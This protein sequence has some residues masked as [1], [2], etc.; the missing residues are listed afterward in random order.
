VTKKQREVLEEIAQYVIPSYPIEGY[1]AMVPLEKVIY[2]RCLAREAL[3]KADR[4]NPYELRAK[5]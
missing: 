1:G 5:Q 2:L 3:P 4:P